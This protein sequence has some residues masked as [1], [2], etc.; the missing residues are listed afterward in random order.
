[1]ELLEKELKSMNL[2]DLS[3]AEKAK[4]MVKVR[5]LKKLIEKYEAN[6]KDDITKQLNG[7]DK[8]IA[9]DYCITNQITIRESIDT[10][11]LKIDHPDIAKD[12]TKQT[13]YYTLKIV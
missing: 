2:T 10:K 5:E 8:V 9:G 4:T 1:M 3:L 7:Q 13:I 12:Y 6:L 11:Q